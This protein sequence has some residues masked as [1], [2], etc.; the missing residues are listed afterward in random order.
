MEAC[1]ICGETDP[2]KMSLEHSIPRFLGG[3]KSS[4]QFKKQILCKSC[5]SKLGI[6]V[7]MRFARSTPVY[8]VLNKINKDYLYGFSTIS[9][10][11]N[12]EINN[13]L[14]SDQYIEMLVN[15]SCTAFWIKSNTTQFLGLHGGDPRQSRKP[16]QLYL[17]INDRPI[18][19]E[20][21]DY[22]KINIIR[23]VVSRVKEYF[24]K[25]KKIEIL[26]LQ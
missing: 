23:E 20:G 2:Q 15:L 16:S 19:H 24:S 9:F 10:D 25:Y 11:K 4:I 8:T 3:A 5:N 21:E 26:I 6:D 22:I 12:H 1:F 18:L 17:F 7:D 14:E 13:F